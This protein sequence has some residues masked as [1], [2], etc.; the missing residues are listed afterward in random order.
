MQI[1]QDLQHFP[2]P[3]L[4]VLAD[5]IHA[6]FWMAHEDE[7]DEVDEIVLERE[8]AT[9]H[10]TQFVNTNHGGSVSTP[11][12]HDEDRQQKFVHSVKARIEEIA[13]E[14]LTEEVML[15]MPA[16]LSHAIS[17][18]LEGDVKGMV[19]KTLPVDLMKDAMTDVLRRLTTLA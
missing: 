12:K 6:K 2:H 15:V 8:R 4:I 18:H 5:N 13:R 17:N 7:A 11:E 19:K 9:D 16:E 3:T 10:E 14:G 1:P